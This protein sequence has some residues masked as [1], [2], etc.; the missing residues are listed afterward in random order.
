M[1]RCPSR[2]ATAASA[3]PC[4]RPTSP[5]AAGASGRRTRTTPAAR[6]GASA[7]ACWQTTPTRSLSRTP[8]QTPSPPPSLWTLPPLPRST[9]AT[10]PRTLTPAAGEGRACVRAVHV[11]GRAAAVPRWLSN[12]SRPLP[13]LLPRPATPQ[14]QAPPRRQ[15]LPAASASRGDR[16]PHRQRLLGLLPVSARRAASDL[17]QREGTARAQRCG[18]TLQPTARAAAPRRTSTACAPLA[19]RACQ[20]RR[21]PQ[22][23]DCPAP[24]PPPS[25][26]C[27]AL[28][29]YGSR[30]WW[31]CCYAKRQI[32]GAYD[33]TCRGWH[34][35]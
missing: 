2:A 29:R 34:G 18:A 32:A 15:G 27:A 1:T 21:H 26:R 35:H 19:A 22:D 30:A 31:A 25:P 13:G 28:F 5:P 16:L 9:A 10:S 4:R 12:W 8:R 11:G 17:P 33:P 23:K 7:A 14:P 6:A 20:R 3:P 24:P